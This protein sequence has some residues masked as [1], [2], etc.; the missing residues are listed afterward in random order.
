MG[1]PTAPI[2]I[3]KYPSVSECSLKCHFNYNY[4][5]TNFQGSR[6]SKSFFYELLQDNGSHVVFNNEQY[7]LL[8]MFIGQ[9][10]HTYGGTYNDGELII[11]N[12]NT[13]T[14][15]NVWICIP[16]KSSFGTDSKSTLID[17]LINPLSNS[18]DDD[19][20]EIKSFKL[21]SLIAKKPFYSYQ[22]DMPGGDT[23]N[24]VIYYPGSGDDDY[25]IPISKMAHTQISKLSSL[26]LNIQ[27]NNGRLA[28]NKTG[29]IRDISAGNDEIYIDCQPT[30]SEGDTL[31]EKKTHSD[32][33][34]IN[35]A[36]EGLQ[37]SLQIIAGI[38]IMYILWRLGNSI[39]AKITVNAKEGSPVITKVR[40]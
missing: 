29:P 5:L 17:E 3:I 34:N 16:L 6:S 18:H 27:P 8:G 7:K 12:K 15:K 14:G 28:Y 21:N 23:V 40:R 11:M 31:I 2:N 1:K 26:G 4:H 35:L 13:S 36:N 37:Y 32:L 10:I 30:N 20:V 9:S 38:F 25:S 19:S 24:F 39:L 22:G 33:F